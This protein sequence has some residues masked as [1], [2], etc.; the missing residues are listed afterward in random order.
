MF[1][2]PF[3]KQRYSHG[4]LVILLLIL[5]ITDSNAQSPWQ[6]KWQGKL[7]VAAGMQ[8]TLILNLQEQDGKLSA[9]LD[10]PDQGAMGIPASQVSTKDT[11]LTVEFAAISAR[12]VANLKEQQL[13]GTFYQAGQQFPLVLTPMSTAQQEAITASQQRP[14]EPLPPYPYIEQQV[15][16]PHPSAGFNFAGTL[17]LPQGKGPFS[18]A[19]LITGSGPQ[20]RDETLANH[21]PFK[22]LADTLTRRGFAVLRSDDRGTGQSAGNFSGATIEDFA[23]DVQAAYEYLL[24]RE[25]INPSKIGLIG[26][27]EGGVTGPLFA[28]RQPKV[29]FVIMLAGLGVPGNQ[30]WATQQRDIGLASGMQDGDMIYQLHL[31]A[32]TLSAQGANF[33]QIKT[34]FAAVP[35]ANEQ[36][37]NTLATMLSSDWAH[38]LMAYQPQAVLIKLNMPLLALN[39]ERDMQVASKDN[40][41]GIKQIMANTANQDVTVLSLPEL[42][43]LFQ[44]APTGHPAEYAQISETLNPAALAHISD[45]LAARF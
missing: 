43:H 39:G 40:L 10:S 29:A 28:A 26:H 19:I 2:L 8:L 15:R 20:D 3:C 42:N 33:E 41:T 18:A 31:K 35:N 12:Y 30:L 38:S 17:T 36:M 45:W 34:L 27:S 37:I 5:W 23:T 4:F 25:D 24:S 16:Y 13:Q 44:Q 6:Q 1:N 11:E 7:E 9:T 14:Q 32:A 21:K 22:L